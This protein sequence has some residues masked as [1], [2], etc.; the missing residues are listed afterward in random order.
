MMPLYYLILLLFLTGC[1]APLDTGPMSPSMAVIKDAYAQG[2]LKNNIVVTSVVVPEDFHTS[3]IGSI[4]SVMLSDVL[5]SALNAS[6]YLNITDKN[7]KYSLDVTLVELATPAFGF[8]MDGKSIIEYKLTNTA[9]QVVLFDDMI[10]QGY[11]AN[12]GEAYNATLRARIARSKAIREN[13]SQFLHVLRN[14]DEETIIESQTKRR[15][16]KK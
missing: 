6:D 16:S 14:I 9:N 15:K 11:I 12:F 1:A 10:V 3:D 7:S 4:D 13:V 8:D 5:A 2:D